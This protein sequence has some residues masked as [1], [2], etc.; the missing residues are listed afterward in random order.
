MIENLSGLISSIHF[1]TE[2]LEAHDW[3]E[4]A[5][6]KSIEK[7]SEYFSLCS[8]NDLDLVKADLGFIF[9][10]NIAIIIFNYIDQVYDNIN[11]QYQKTG[12]NKD[13]T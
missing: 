1:E 3:D 9:S 5:T 13:E 10:E 4:Q 7:L 12:E 2:M 11:L 6:K 8:K